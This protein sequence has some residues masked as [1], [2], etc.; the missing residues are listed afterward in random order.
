MIAP[1]HLPQIPVPRRAE[2][3]NPRRGA[4][5]HALLEA[6][7][8]AR[9]AIVRLALPGGGQRDGLAVGGVVEVPEG[10]LRGDA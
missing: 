8:A 2:G 5:V 6:R 4:P 7:P 1:H 9:E 10:K 3:A